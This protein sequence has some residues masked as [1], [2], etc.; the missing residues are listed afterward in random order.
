MKILSTLLLCLICLP[1]FAQTLSINNM[2]KACDFG[3][4]KQHLFL[5][6]KG[7]TLTPSSPESDNSKGTYLFS[8]PKTKE[9]LIIQY[10]LVYE[11]NR[12]LNALL[13]YSFPD[14]AQLDRFKS[15]LKKDGFTYSK[16]NGYYIKRDGTYVYQTI[17]FPVEPVASPAKTFKIQYANHI[18]KEVMAFPSEMVN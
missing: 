11:A 16:R 12:G 13:E 10:D 3:K 2:P 8:C 17:T 5:I 14:K 9:Q 7:F 6:K 15:T 18:G 4:D 1:A